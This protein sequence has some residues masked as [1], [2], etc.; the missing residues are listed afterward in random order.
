MKGRFDIMDMRNLK[1]MRMI[2]SPRFAQ[3]RSSPP[4]GAKG[5]DKKLQHLSCWNEVKHLK[6]TNF[7]ISPHCNEMTESDSNIH[8]HYNRKREQSWPSPF[9]ANI[10]P[11]IRTA[12]P[13]PLKHPLLP[14]SKD[15]SQSRRDLRGLSWGMYVSRCCSC[16]Q[17]R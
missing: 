10:Y 11:S 14:Q 7:E 13:V 1:I 6:N 3:K 17:P 4:E 8:P 16:V 9:Y 2:E 12:P 5:N 15:V